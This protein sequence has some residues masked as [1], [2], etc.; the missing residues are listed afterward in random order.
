MRKI[1]KPTIIECRKCTPLVND[2]HW[3]AVRT[4]TREHNAAKMILGMHTKLKGKLMFIQFNDLDLLDFFENEPLV[5]GERDEA[6]FIYSIKDSRQFSMTL[7]VDTYAKII[8][9][10]VR[11]S[12][13]TVFAGE[14]DNVLE[15]RK[16]EDV[17]LV[18]MKNKK[19][20][21]LKKHACF[22]IVIENM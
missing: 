7:A 2:R 19:R 14:F 9:I 10:S 8:D 18:E 15:I 6:K 13:N 20:L 5:I 22:G 17:L 4:F 1:P 21:V 3:D 16:S 11:Y 12:D